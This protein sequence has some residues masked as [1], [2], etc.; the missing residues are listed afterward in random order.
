MVEAE[1]CVCCQEITEIMNK[2][3]EV[4]EKEKLNEKPSCIT[5][6]PP[7]E[8]VCLNHWVLKVA[9]IAYKE[10]HGKKVMKGLTES[11]KK[12]KLACRQLVWFCW[13]TCGKEISVN[14]PS[15]ALLSIRAR[16]APSDV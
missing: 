12:R 1:E 14:L 8:T 4:Y 16:F 10:E 7:F 2:N 13:G 11:E 15:C 3:T 9:E 5:E 6:S